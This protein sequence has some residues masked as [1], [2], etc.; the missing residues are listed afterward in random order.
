MPGPP[1]TRCGRGLQRE[2]VLEWVFWEGLHLVASEAEGRSKLG[3]G[4]QLLTSSR[5]T[6]LGWS[7]QEGLVSRN[8]HSWSR[9][10]PPEGGLACEMAFPD[11]QEGAQ[12]NFTRGRESFPFPLLRNQVK[13][14]RK[15][16]S[17]LESRGPPEGMWQ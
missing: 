8:R 10:W 14:K 2:V 15:P 9:L 17:P 11:T 3:A 6:F 1:R 5:G 12:R 7:G 4:L 16:P 13:G